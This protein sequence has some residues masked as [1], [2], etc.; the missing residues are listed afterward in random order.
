MRMK[1]ISFKSFLIHAKIGFN[2]TRYDTQPHYKKLQWEQYKELYKVYLIGH[3]Y[4]GE[5]DEIEAEL[6]GIAGRQL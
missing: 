5:V 2:Q 6:D 4:L 3:G 1:K